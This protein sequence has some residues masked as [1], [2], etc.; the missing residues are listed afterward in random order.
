MSDP[1]CTNCGEPVMFE[2][3]HRGELGG[4]ETWMCDRETA[5]AHHAKLKAQGKKTEGDRPPEY[6]LPGSKTDW[7]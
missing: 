7:W 5:R 3:R 4:L 2:G 6:S 1:L